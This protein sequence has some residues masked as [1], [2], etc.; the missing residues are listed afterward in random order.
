MLDYKQ[1]LQFLAI[2][3][4]LKCNTRH[5]VTSTGRPESVAEH[6]WRAAL[7]AM[8]LRKEFPGVDINRVI[9]MCLIHDLGEAV[10][11]DIPTFLKTRAD[12][13]VELDAIGQL[14]NT[15][16]PAN[17]TYFGELFTEM[18]SLQTDEA[19]LYKAIDKIEGVI[20]HN[21]A[22]LSSW[23]EREYELNRT[24]GT[25]ECAHFPVMDA[26]RSEVNRQTEEKIQ[27]GE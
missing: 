24:Y 26:L 9:D 21:E 19:R 7:M 27:K 13:E 11:G 18:E 4:K 25:A 3:E 16:D 6:S 20:A 10:T 23:L 8:M 2:A 17:R 5:C 14:L 15:L 22:P 12:E 1:F